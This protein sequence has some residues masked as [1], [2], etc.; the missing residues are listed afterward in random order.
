MSDGYEYSPDFHSDEAESS[1]APDP[2]E[3]HIVVREGHKRECAS[4]LRIAIIQSMTTGCVPVPGHSSE[5]VYITIPP[6]NCGAEPAP[7]KQASTGASAEEVNPSPR[8]AQGQEFKEGYKEGLKD[9]PLYAAL[10]KSIQPVRPAQARFAYDDG[11]GAMYVYFFPEDSGSGKVDCTEEIYPG[12]N[13]DF[14]A[15]G[16][17]FGLEVFGV[18]KR[19]A[20]LPGLPSPAPQPRCVFCD[21]PMPLTMCTATAM[22]QCQKGEGGCHVYQISV[23]GSSPAEGPKPHCL[24]PGCGKPVR[25]AGT[26]S[27]GRIRVVCDNA[28]HWWD[29]YT[30]EELIPFFTPSAGTE[31]KKI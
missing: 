19:V 8:S 26:G 20:A 9:A 1:A 25:I 2:Q 30:L 3:P 4:N 16:K 5:P 10:S 24:K 28:M 21:Q 22:E 17:P 7:A 18:Y 6:C 15:D 23:G 13:L 29:A 14:Y 12:I 11:C 31:E 27:K